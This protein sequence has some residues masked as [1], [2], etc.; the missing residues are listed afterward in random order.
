MDGGASAWGSLALPSLGATRTALKVAEDGH[1]IRADLRGLGPA[2]GEPHT[3]VVFCEPLPLPLGDPVMGT[4]RWPTLAELLGAADHLAPGCVFSL[5][6]VAVP[7][8]AERVEPPEGEP[9]VLEAKQ[10]GAV[11]SG[12][13][14]VGADA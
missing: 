7:D 3:L 14:I 6:F 5:V 4:D 10:V 2:L 1:T 8:G 9:R 11:K 13:V 12:P